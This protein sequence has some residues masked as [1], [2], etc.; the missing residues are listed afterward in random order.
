MFQP[1]AYTKTFAMAGAAILSITLVPALMF[2][3]IRGRIMPEQKNPLT[4]FSYGFTVPIIAWV[5]RWK[6]SPF[7]RPYRSPCAHRSTRREAGQ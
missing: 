2:L 5:M 3:F 6:N 4:A 1:L 7:S